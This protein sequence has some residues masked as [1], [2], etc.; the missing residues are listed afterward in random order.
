MATVKNN[1]ED[2]INKLY[3]GVQD[4]QKELLTEAYSNNTGALDTE[5]QNVQNQTDQYLERT[6]V[7]AQRVNQQYKPPR[8][9][10]AVNQQAALTMENQQKK[11]TQM[12]QMQQQNAD[13]E[14][15]RLRKLYADQYAAEIKK[16]QANNDMARAQMLYEAAKAT[17]QELKNFSAQ[18]GT[19]DNQALLDQIYTNSMEGSRQELDIQRAQKLSELAAQQQAAQQKTDENLTKVYTDALQ[20]SKNYNEV[21]TARGMGSGNLAQAQ[22]A[23]DTGTTEALT[24][25]R[26][27]QLA[28]DANMGA[29][30]V[31]VQKNYGDSYASMVGNTERQRAEAMYRD[32]L[33]QQQ[34]GR[35]SIGPGSEVGGTVATGGNRGSGGTV[36]ENVLK[37]QEV[38]NKEGYNVT[39]DGIDGPETQGASYKFVQDT[40]IDAIAAGNSDGIPEILDAAIKEGY[41]TQNQADEIDR[42]TQFMY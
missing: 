39:K 13:A 31:G 33:T 6:D 38:L 23:R 10:G 41:I 35:P 30:R 36:D 40:V 21:Q 7:E 22:L 32:A 34:T 28:A 16:A 24:E 19:L 14:Y 25:L 1:A 5:K 12:L 8:V 26:K 2:Y 29:S 11:N 4:K 42:S 20:Q 15:E 3:D 18:I 9:S 37:R 17:E 27:A